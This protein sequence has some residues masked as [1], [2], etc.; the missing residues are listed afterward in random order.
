MAIDI[1][2]STLT[3]DNTVIYT[4]NGNMFTIQ[5]S[6]NTAG[7]KPYRMTHYYRGG[8]KVPVISN[9]ANIPSSGKI[10]LNH[11]YGASRI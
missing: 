11:F 5:K 7:T 4:V 2:G 3:V 8:A 1:T 6:Y 10:S 9:T